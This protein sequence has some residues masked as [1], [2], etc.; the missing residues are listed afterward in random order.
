MGVLQQ[1]NRAVLLGSEYFPFLQWLLCTPGVRFVC[2]INVSY[3]LSSPLPQ[4]QHSVLCKTTL[5]SPTL[6]KRNPSKP[7]GAA[8]IVASH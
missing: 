2:S 5:L 6:L 4:I 7:P 3:S 1:T 8:W